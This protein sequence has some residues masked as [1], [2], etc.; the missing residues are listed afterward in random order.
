MMQKV[1]Y[2]KIRRFFREEYNNDQMIC[3]GKAVVRDN[4][5]WKVIAKRFENIYSEEISKRK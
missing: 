4:Y 3:E 2:E 5:S 1:F